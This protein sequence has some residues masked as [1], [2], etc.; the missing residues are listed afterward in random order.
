MVGAGIGLPS[1]FWYLILSSIQVFLA[2]LLERQAI[3]NRSLDTCIGECEYLFFSAC[4]FQSKGTGQFP[5]IFHFER[6]HKI[7]FEFAN[8]KDIISIDDGVISIELQN[9]AATGGP[10]NEKGMIIM[11]L[12]G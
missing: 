3:D 6:L 10:L 7:A 2:S 4:D 11:G 5:H 8:S 9:S 1:S 12:F